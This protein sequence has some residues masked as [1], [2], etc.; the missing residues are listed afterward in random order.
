MTKPRTTPVCQR[1]EF[2]PVLFSLTGCEL[3]RGS[4]YDESTLGGRLGVLNLVSRF[5]EKSLAWLR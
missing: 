3:N 4:R 5:G 1:L 2:N